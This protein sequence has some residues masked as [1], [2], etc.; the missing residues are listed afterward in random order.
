V[1]TVSSV[2]KV[3]F[4]SEGIELVGNLHIPDNCSK[5]TPAVVIIGPMTYVKEQAPTEYAKRLAQHGFTALVFDARYRGES[6]G[7]PRAYENPM[8]KVADIHAA[9]DYL[10]TRPEIDPDR[11]AGLAICQGSSE[12]IRAAA[13][14]DRI[15]VLATLAG[16]Y[17]DHQGDVDWL[18]EAGL[19]ERRQKGEQAKKKFE[20]TGEVDYVPAIDPVRADVGMPGKIVWDWYHVW[21][22]QGVWENRYAVMSDA[23]LLAYESASAAERL[24]KPY[25]MIHSDNSFLPSAARRHFDLIP[26]ADKQLLWGGETG[27]LQYYDDPVVIDNAIENIVA[28]FNKYLG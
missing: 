18:G 17:R 14:D 25:L 22:D 11:I 26:H 19:V 28:W 1:L 6:G 27:H 5:P 13:D 7:E 12:M 9:I 21:A 2:L 23:D 8:D 16:Q 20:Q 4:N 10:V 3:S 24:H 15:K